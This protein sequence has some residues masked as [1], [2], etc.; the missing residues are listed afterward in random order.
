MKCVVAALVLA[1]SASAAAQTAPSPA[2]P[3]PV[4]R[5]L[6]LEGASIF[7]RDD[8]EWLLKLREGSPLPGPADEVAKALQKRYDRDGYSEARVSAAFDAGR[9]TLTV[10]EGRI[11]DIEIVG[12]SNAEKDRYRTRLDVKPGDIYNA[13]VIAHMATRLE[14]E[15]HGAVAVGRPY[16]TQPGT[17]PSEAEHAPENVT[18]ERRGTRNVLV[19]PLRWRTARTN[20]GLDSGSEDF[21]S[22]VDGLAP[23]I[24]YHATF[25]DHGEFNHAFVDSYVAYKFGSDRPGYS[26]GGE[27]PIFR[28]PKLFL[29]AEFHDIST[30]DDLWRLTGP[31]QTVA[32]LG[33]KNSFRDYYRRRGVQIFG[34]LQAG[35]NNEFSVIARWD[36]QAPLDNATN[37][38]FFRDD[39][40]YRPNPRVIDEHVNALVFGYT[41]DTRPLTGAGEQATYRRHL[42][43]DLFGFG[44]RRQPGL[45][46]EWTSEVAGHGLDGDA[47]FERHVL[48]ARGYLALS[49]HTLASVRGLFGWG[50]GDLPLERQF[51][52]GGIGSVHGYAFKEAAGRGLTLINAEY[53]VKIGPAIGHETEGLSVFA[54]YD[55]GRTTSLFNKDPAPW[56]R[57]IGAGVGLAG[58]RVEFG[59]RQNDIPH[60]RQILVRF[61]PTF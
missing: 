13:R 54:F 8:V 17:L 55:A 39:A 49:S 16:R 33:F 53:R 26:A 58:V 21:F 5:E 19:V 60:S 22:P 14:A 1:I 32:S 59:F 7:T 42:K 31:E 50:G 18:L 4:L 11:D 27:R 15:S 2:Q 30:S 56:L 25:F 20:V 40:T 46:L 48:N 6:R 37:Y 23:G 34:V 10:D 47:R 43:D 51:A 57:G 24:D 61:A 12:V 9:L 38:S 36:H 41:F 28:S 52:I 35:Q 3:L 45:R 29:G 44:G